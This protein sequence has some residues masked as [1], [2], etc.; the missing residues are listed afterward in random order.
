MILCETDNS[1]S[2]ES[3]MQNE[4]T[5]MEKPSQPMDIGEEGG[6]D[7]DILVP[8]R[9]LMDIDMVGPDHT[10]S[11]ETTSPM[12]IIESSTE[13][14]QSRKVRGPYRRYTEHQIE[15]LF[16]YVIKQG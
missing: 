7:D 12:T 3:T 13:T 16:D 6:N 5:M 2:T 9:P 15:Q 8:L 4:E 10:L 14:H 1:T 11:T